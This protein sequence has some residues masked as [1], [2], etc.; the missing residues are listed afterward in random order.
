LVI[1]G[2]DRNGRFNI[3]IEDKTGA[4]VII[5]FSGAIDISKYNTEVFYVFLI[6]IIIIGINEYGCRGLSF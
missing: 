2:D 3:I 1:N 6:Y 4:T 5:K